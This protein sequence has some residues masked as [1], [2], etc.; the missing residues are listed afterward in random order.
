MSISREIVSYAMKAGSSDIHLEEGSPIAVRVNSDIK[1]SGQKLRSQ[2]MDNLMMELLGK[3]K[4]NEFN[5]LGDLDSSTSI[6]GL[7]RLRINAYIANEKRCLTLR[8]LPDN[9][10]KW[11]DLGLP[12]PFIK[13][14]KLERGMVLC[15][16]PTGSGKSTT[17]A[18]FINCIL[19]TQK[20]H[21]LTIEDPIEFIFEHTENSIIH[22]RE[23]K[24]DT[25]SFARALKAALRED[26]DVIYIGE[27]RDLETIQLAITA[28]ETGHL[29]LGTLHTSSAAKTVERIVDV[30]PGDQQEQARLQV[31][32]S[33]AGIMS[34]TLCKNT[35][36]KRS[37]AYELLINTPAIGNLIRE[38]K[39]SQIYSQLQTGSNDGMNTLEQ[40]LNDLVA[41]GLITKELALS[42]ASV[43]KAID[44]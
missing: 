40:C 39:V 27:M 4:V 9:L 31:S 11:Q 19:E 6:E 33:L 28:A 22:Q 17:L 8:L 36:G 35:L 44:E 10:P 18:A 26:P 16:G 7:S 12:E 29:V 13:L 14:S 2:D 34:Q 41:Q 21:I 1:I 43:T 23:V 38:R 37:L 42:K 25:D 24:R 20:R 5:E 32:T 3:E 30:F 15:T